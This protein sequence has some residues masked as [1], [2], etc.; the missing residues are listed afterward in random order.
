MSYAKEIGRI[1][2]DMVAN[3]L[4]SR[5]Y[6]ILRQNYHSKFGEIDIVAESPEKLLFVEVKTRRDNSLQDPSDS[7]DLEKQRKII[8]TAYDFLRKLHLKTKV[9]FDIAEVT[10]SVCDDNK[11][12]SLNYIKNAFSADILKV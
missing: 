7:V 6:I 1:G 9:R 10:Y 11:K 8:S 3:F 2:E 4:R 12:F 5:G